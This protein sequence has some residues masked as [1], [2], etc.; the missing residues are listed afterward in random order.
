MIGLLPGLSLSLELRSVWNVAVDH[1]S[2]DFDATLG[3]PGEGPLRFFVMLDLFYSLL[4]WLSSL[5]SVLH[6][7]GSVASGLRSSR[8]SCRS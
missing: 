6:P 1:S 8:R 7:D 3:Y 4:S 5:L 2:L